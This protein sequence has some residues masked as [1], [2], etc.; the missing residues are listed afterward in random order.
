MIARRTEPR[1]PLGTTVATPDALDAIAAAE[2]L[3]GDF[4]DRHVVGNWGEVSN[5]D[6]GLNDEALIH[7]ERLLSVYLTSLGVR[8]WVITEA[9]RSVTT[10]LLPSEY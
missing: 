9:D 5:E 2:Q 10:I 3:P 1:F 4:L 6:A 8:L 7:G